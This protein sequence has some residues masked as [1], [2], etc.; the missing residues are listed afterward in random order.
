MQTLGPGG[1]STPSHVVVNGQS[2]DIVEDFVYL[3]SKISNTGRSEPDILRRLGLAS[4]AM[5]SLR[6]I[7]RLKSLKLTTKLGIYRTCVIPVLLYGSETWT[8]LKP[9]LRRL[10]SFH[11]RSQRSILGIQWFNFISNIEV[12]HRTGLPTI[13]YQIQRRRT[14]FFGHVA[15]LADNIPAKS[16]LGIAVDS[17]RGKPPGPGW[18]RPRGRPRSSWQEQLGRPS[19]IDGMWDEAVGRGHRRSA[20]RTFAVYA[21][22]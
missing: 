18:K 3:G 15:R 20:R 21:D 12:T 9:D 4:S 7:W 19:V 16:A 10:E 11:Q 22:D 1:S 8:L 14:A 6:R 5:N 2:V 13:N 17:R